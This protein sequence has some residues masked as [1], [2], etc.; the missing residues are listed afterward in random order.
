MWGLFDA[1]FFMLGVNKKVKETNKL[2]TLLKLLNWEKCRNHLKNVHKNDIDPQ[3]GQK[4]YDNLKMFKTLL[5]QQ[6][7]SLSDEETEE[8]LCVRIDFML[9]TSFELN[10]DIPDASTIC[11]FRNKLIEKNLDTKLFQEINQQLEKLGLKLHKAK[12]AVIDATI[13]ESASR[14]RKTI[15]IEQDREESNTEIQ[16]EES[17]DPDA[18]WLKKG[19]RCYFGYKCFSIVDIEGYY[20]KTHTESAN[21]AEIDK[22]ETVMTGVKIRRLLGDKG[23]AS[24]KNRELLKE[25]KIKDGIMHK[26]QKNK[27]LTPR[28][29]LINKLISKQRYIVEQGFGTLKRKFKFERASYT[30][31]RKV[32][33]QFTLKAICFNLLKAVNKIFSGKIVPICT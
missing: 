33:G 2:V 23:Y 7:Q 4:A 14:P 1:Y 3:G 20:D 9:F 6:W 27:E 32:Q 15:N 30:T 21:E 22:L 16:V 31:K 18:R 26:A 28:Q 10:D 12:G 5:L 17:K 19:K 13:I 11:R 29:K 8:A 25:K 24:A